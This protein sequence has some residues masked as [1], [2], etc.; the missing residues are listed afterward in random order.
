MSI[1]TKSMPSRSLTHRA[2]MGVTLG[3]LAGLASGCADEKAPIVRV[4]P[5]V[6]SKSFFVGANL[7]KH[8]DDPEFFHRGYVVDG[9]ASQSEIGVGT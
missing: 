5:Q 2:A 1:R 3:L 6:L 9:S 4:Q 8:E 7:S